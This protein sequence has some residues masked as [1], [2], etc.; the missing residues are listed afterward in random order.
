MALLPS[1]QEVHY[2]PLG[3]PG[4]HYSNATSLMAKLSNRRV[5]LALFLVGL[6]GTLTIYH[7]SED[8]SIQ[9]EGSSIQKTNVWQSWTDK[10]L[11]GSSGSTSTDYTPKINN[12]ALAEAPPSTCSFVPQAPTSSAPPA[13]AATIEQTHHIAEEDW[14][15][16]ADVHLEEN[17]PLWISRRKPFFKQ[18][19][20]DVH[21]ELGF[22]SQSIKLSEAPFVRRSLYRHLLQSFNTF[23]QAHQ[24]HFWL[25]HGSLLGQTW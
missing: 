21:R 6:L 17:D 10:M 19:K 2:E 13:A 24:F 14:H 7:K 3:K 1:H 15:I 5:I 8:I 23:A 18:I 25:A 16:P 9:A 12:D 4:P 20:G 11:K 22:G